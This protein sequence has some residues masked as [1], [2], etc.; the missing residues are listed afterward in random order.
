MVNIE[1]LRNLIHLFVIYFVINN[2]S[3]SRYMKYK[4]EIPLNQTEL[5]NFYFRFEYYDNVSSICNQWVPSLFSPT[6]L[7]PSKSEIKGEEIFLFFD[8]DIKYP[9]LNKNE[10]FQIK[11]Y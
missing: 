5:Q 2:I 1:N 11:L 9:F 6:L 4:L 8:N 10:L 7:V 3:S